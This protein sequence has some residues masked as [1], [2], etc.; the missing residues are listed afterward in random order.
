MNVDILSIFVIL[1]DLAVV[2]FLTW[3]ST[4]KKATLWGSARI[5]Y[6]YVAAL[7]L[8]HAVIYSITLLSP[9][10][11]PSILID[12]YLHPFVFLFVLNPC[13]IAIIHWRGGRL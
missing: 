6:L 7:T 9:G 5:I 3:R 13:L 8:Y 4:A 10:V 2:S 11:N 1:F 12:K